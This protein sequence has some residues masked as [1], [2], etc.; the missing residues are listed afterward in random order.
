MGTKKNIAACVWALAE[1][2][3]KELGY[4]LWDVEYV[5]EGAT[6]IL[7]VTIDSEEEGGIT[8]SDCERM[9]RAMDPILDEADPI[10]E[11]YSFEVS[12]PGIERTLTRPEHFAAMAGAEIEIRLFASLP[13]RPAIGASKV[14]RG[15]LSGFDGENLLVSV[16]ADTVSVPRKA[17]AKVQTVYHW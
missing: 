13:N 8:L 17:A 15:I 7:R 16:G 10:E 9:T 11:S 1:P 3:A 4:I 2:V 6:M 12:S 14:F 5:K